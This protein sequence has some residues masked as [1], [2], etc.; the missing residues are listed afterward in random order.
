M[1]GSFDRVMEERKK[2][3]NRIIENMKNG[4][5]LPKPQWNSTFSFHNP[6]SHARYRGAN[7]LKL[8]LAAET[9]GYQDSRWMTFKQAQ[10]MGYRVKKGAKGVRLEKYIFTRQEEQL[11]EDTGEMEKVTVR[12]DRPMVNSFVVFNGEQI[13][14]IPEFEP[15]KPLEE[16]DVWKLA[17]QLIASSECP[18]NEK[19]Q[20]RA[21]YKPMEDSIT[22]PPRNVFVSPEAFTTVLMHEMVHST[23]HS[24]RL[25]RQML[26]MFGSVEYAKEELRAELGSYFMGSDLGIEG[27]EELLASHTQYLESWIGV[28]EKD[29]N[30]LFRACSD[31][32]KAV[33]RLSDNLERYLEQVKE[34]AAEKHS[35]KMDLDEYLGRQGLSSP[36]SDYTMDKTKIPHGETE[37]QRQKRLNETDKAIRDYHS[38]RNEA[39]E[40]Y[41]AKVEKGEIISKTKEE[42]KLEK[43]QGHPDNASVQAARRMLVKRGMMSENELKNK[44]TEWDANITQYEAAIEEALEA[45]ELQETAFEME[46]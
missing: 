32:Q 6:V 20:D 15:M 8:Y 33:D 37:R 1:S 31:A 9:A 26:N 18:V 25:N 42:R 27:S 45:A 24:S 10:Q 21:F 29:P 19:K 12:L 4:Y 40:E 36:V 2:L 7:M 28:L 34:K 46:M 14:G 35:V 13:E 23:G 3:V 16:S 22:L 30:E 38:R 43:A 11:N 39:I 44:I 41:H 5:I 17:D